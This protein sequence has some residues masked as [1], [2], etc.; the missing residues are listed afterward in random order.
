MIKLHNSRNYIIIKS[1]KELVAAKQ[2]D[3]C[4]FIIWESGC[5]IRI[6]ERHPINKW[7]EIKYVL[8]NGKEEFP[9]MISG[10]EAYMRFY[11]YCGRNAV[12]EMKLILPEIAI[13]E[14]EEQ[15]HY[16][17]PEHANE[18]IYKPIYVFDANSSFTYGALQL[19]EKFEPL[20]EYMKSEYE[21]KKN[22]PNKVERTKHKAYQNFLIGY[23]ARIKKFISTR[24]NIILGS[25]NNIKDRISEIVKNNGTVYLSNTD[26]IVTDDKGREVMLDYIGD[27][28]GAFKLEKTSDRLIYYSPN[29]YQ[30]G[31]KIT[32][33]GIKYFERIN[34]D[35]FEG[36]RAY[37]SGSL[38]KPFDFSLFYDNTDYYKLCRVE[39]GIIKVRVVNKIG[40]LIDEIIYRA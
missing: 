8:F 14:S 36:K 13:W 3:L 20:K 32:Y 24:S 40:E 27:D 25:N 29:A 37:Q 15:M 38:I 31:D 33:S 26:S 1:Y 10:R 16:A 35:L 39:L 6:Y 17:N 19:P 11:N 2:V 21:L 4:D 34:S 7:V 28:V 12:E 22:A 30:I 18:A 5:N 9:N 23:F